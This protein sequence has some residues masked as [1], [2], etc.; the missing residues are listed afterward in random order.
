MICVPI[1][2]NGNLEEFSK[3]KKLIII[4]KNGKVLQEIEN[5]AIKSKMKRPAVARACIELNAD[6][7]IAPHGSLCLPSYR[8][9]KSKKVKIMISNKGIRLEEAKLRPVS[10]GEI[11]YSSL[12][13]ISERI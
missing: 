9:L 12:I 5:P 1:D 11:M 7:V 3:A 4:D 10:M 2:E 8:I 13:A 6:E